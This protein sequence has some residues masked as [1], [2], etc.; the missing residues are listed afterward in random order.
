MLIS[1]YDLNHKFIEG[2][3]DFAPLL[4][5]DSGGYE[6][7]KEAELSDFGEHEHRA[8][9]WSEQQY[10]QEVDK[11]RSLAKTIFVSYDHPNERLKLAD[12]VKR[13]KTYFPQNPDGCESF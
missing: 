1:A 4:F 13:A 2:P 5:L 12:E 3:F 11:W 10:L 9:G 7:S 8:L 6:A